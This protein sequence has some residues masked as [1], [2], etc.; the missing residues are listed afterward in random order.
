MNKLIMISFTG[1]VI[2]GC[3]RSIQE[4]RS[5]IDHTGLPNRNTQLE[6]PQYAAWVQN[7]ENDLVKNKTINDVNYQVAF[8]PVEFMAYTE[9]KH[10]EYTEQQ[11]K[12]TKAHYAGMSYFKL[13]IEVKDHTGEILKY[14]LSSAQQYNQRLDY[15][16]F[17]MQNDLC[18]VQGKDTLYPGLYH[19]ER[20][21][22][23]APFADVML[24]FDNQKFHPEEEFTIVYNDQLF[25]KGYLK[26]I[27]HQKQLIDL[28]NI[29]NA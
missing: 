18:I 20:S 27:Y 4:Q 25:N 24:A 10:Q 8:L 21:Y 1:L 5:N 23:L 6:L 22:D 12:E 13:R 15:M 14:E 26:Y 9:L 28:P 3:G 17:R 29:P 2:S 16:A 19:F 7:E 11:F